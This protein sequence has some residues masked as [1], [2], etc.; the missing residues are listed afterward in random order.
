MEDVGIPEMFAEV[1]NTIFDKLRTLKGGIPSAPFIPS[2]S[3]ITLF[4]E[5]FLNNMDINDPKMRNILLDLTHN[6]NNI[7]IL[8][9]LENLYSSFL[10]I[11]SNKVN[12][13]PE[14]QVSNILILFG[15]GRDINTS[16]RLILRNNNKIELVGEYDLHQPS[17]DKILNGM[18]KF[19]QKIGKGGEDGLIVPLW[20]V[21]AIRQIT[22][23]PMGGCSMGH[24]ASDGVVDSLGRV[25][26]GKTRNQGYDNLYV[27][28]G[29]IIP[30]FLGINPSLTIPAFAYRIA[31]YIVD[32][33]K[34]YLP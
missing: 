28:D 3:F 32:K 9:D 21:Q 25:F 5:M 24:A 27:A 10:Q 29:S 26:R 19:A 16:C 11:F 13:T 17:Y 7:T 12:P 34:E 22:A 31:F 8:S 1:F 2:K 30:T 6:F 14:E 15:M 4:S 18:K 23:H 33:N 20:D